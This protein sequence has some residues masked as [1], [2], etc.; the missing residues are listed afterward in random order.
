MYDHTILSAVVAGVLEVAVAL[1]HDRATLVREAGLDPALLADPDARLPVEHDLRLWEA[2]ARAPVGLEVGARLGVASLGVVGYAIQHGGT[3]GDAIG[4]L[5]RYREVVHPDLVPRTERRDG[6]EGARV[7]FTKP[8]P[9]PFARLRE[10][11]YAQASATVAAMRALSGR[12]VRARYVAYP[13]ARAADAARHERWFG[14]PVSCGGAPLDV[15][16]DAPLLDLPLPRADARLFG[17]LA[18]RVAAIEAELP[19]AGA[20]DERARREVAALVA[21]GEPRLAD[22]A[23]R[24]A[25]SERTLH[26]R[27]AGEG[28]RF[29]ALLDDAR[30]ERA[31]L[32]LATPHLSSSEVA[33]LLGY[34]EPAAFYRAF[35]RWTGETPGAWRE[36]AGPRGSGLSSTTG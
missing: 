4:W 18:R 24:L 17:Y 14:C 23:R 16:L 21:H 12:D 10:P 13:L 8:V 25:V 22:V 30:R 27:L 33:F 26:R 7:V 28:L 20:V 5:D 29:A 1:G 2:L 35:R 3:V 6:P 11:V 36:K 15:A 31:E 32:L 34:A 19:A 9:A